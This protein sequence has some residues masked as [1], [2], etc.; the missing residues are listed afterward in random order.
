M[1][2]GGGWFH[3]QGLFGPKSQLSNEEATDIWTQLSQKFAQEASGNAIGF[4]NGARANGI[5]NLI[6]YPVLLANPKVINVITGG[7]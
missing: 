5:F 4:V 3:K 1:S 2:S 6:E 7:N